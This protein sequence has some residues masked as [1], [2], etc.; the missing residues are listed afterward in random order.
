MGFQRS[1][2]TQARLEL[3]LAEDKT[4]YEVKVTEDVDFGMANSGIVDA[5]IGSCNTGNAETNWHSCLDF[6]RINIDEYKRQ[7]ASK[8]PEGQHVRVPFKKFPGMSV[9]LFDYQLMGVYNLIRLQL[10]HVSGGFLCDEQGLGKTQEMFGLIALAHNLR[11]CKTEVREFWSPKAQ[12]S[13][14]VKRGS[15][16]VRHNAKGSEARSCQYDQKY[17]FRCYC[18]HEQTR[19]IAD[20]LPDG[21]NIVVA[22][23]RSCG[24]LIREA[25]TKLD[26]KSL[27]IRGYGKNVQK[28]NQLTLRDSLPEYHYQAGAG[29]S[30][31]IIFISPESIDKLNAELTIIVKGKKKSALL[32]GIIM[33]DEFHEYALS[34][35][36]RTLAWLS[37]LKK[38]TLSSQQPSPLVYFVSGTP[39]DK[40]PADIGPPI[41]LLEKP[42]LW[43]QPAHPLFPASSSQFQDLVTTFNAHLNT[44]SLGELVPPGQVKA[45]YARLTDLLTPLM[46]RRLVTDSFLSR[47]LTTLSC[48]LKIS[49]INH[50]IPQPLRP[51]HLALKN[52][53]LALVPPDT[54]P[55]T[56]FRNPRNHHHLLPLLISSTFPS[57]PSHPSSSNFQFTD[58]EILSFPSNPILSPYRP[59][60]PSWTSNSP[61]L[62]SVLSAISDMLSDAFR[63]PGAAS[64]SLKK[65][66]LLSPHEAE[67]HI[68]FLCL[69]K[70]RGLRPAYVH[71]AL[72]QADRQKVIDGFLR[73]GNAAPNL[74]VM[75][76]A[77]GGTGLNLQRASYCVITGAAWTRRE[78]EQGFGRVW[79]V[80]QR[81]S[82]VRLELLV[83]EAGW[84]EGEVVLG[85]WGGALLRGDKKKTK[86]EEEEEEEDE[87][88]DKEG[89][90]GGNK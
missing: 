47:P 37:H 29:Q 28:D 72:G 8:A 75:S 30:D 21:P 86:E 7:M 55:L 1:R 33:L 14:G 54:S 48:P 24:P 78:V 38:C 36:G 34:Q 46:I 10:N 51:S 42:D 17:G 27:K 73:E 88:G 81:A 56:F 82:K 60:I 43:S 18:Y 31:Y 65:M 69:P 25:R 32:P 45:Y 66:L 12:S 84:A 19:Q 4:D 49:I 64:C 87:E 74:L 62:A 50:P 5:Y 22:P 52:H 20:L 61:K 58:S 90:D 57:L 71:P 6:F 44:Q 39:I 85:G 80:G 3:T 15:T 83:C 63:I 40:S 76:L 67:S 77:T 53:L 59:Y 11:R 70:L 68:M 35:E 13:L 89:K 79:R 23:A 16:C 26:I 2:T 41:T 9:G